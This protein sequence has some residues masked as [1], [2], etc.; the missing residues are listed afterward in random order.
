[1][2]MERYNNPMRDQYL[3][4]LGRVVARVERSLAEPLSLDELSGEAALSKFHLHRVFR[5]LTGIP[6]AEYVRRRRLGVS[7]KTLA[8]PSRSVL[9]VALDSGFSHEQSYIR[10]FKARWGLTPGSWRTRK[11]LLEVTEPIE[12]NGLVSVGEESALLAPRLVVRP[13]MSLC[14]VLHLVNDADNA[15]ENTVARVANRFFTED[16]P[17]I[18][19]PVF[20][21]RYVGYVEHCPDPADNRYH[22]CAELRR[23][24]R[25]PPP[26]GM[27][28]VGIERGTFREFLLVS[29]VHPSRL[30]WK[31]VAALYGAVWNDWLPRHG[32]CTHA[33][34]HL[35]YVDLSA[36]A[37]D[38]GEFRILLPIE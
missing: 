4:I 13:P 23:A 21:D 9:E 7:L 10:A 15:A 14:G 34:W 5:A 12:L 28:Y 19:E 24:P 25:R 2:R 31:D 27:R 33:G 6:L 8:D 35:E 32:E 3:S 26:E 29:R 11:P 1:M 38:Y 17:R 22:A 30:G 37:E 20:A 36:A 18:A 16:F